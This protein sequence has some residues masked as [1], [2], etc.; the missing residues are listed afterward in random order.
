MQT[1][2]LSVPPL[3]WRSRCWVVGAMI[4][5]WPMLVGLV[6]GNIFVRTPA[7]NSQ[8][9]GWYYVDQLGFYL[10]FLLVSLLVFFL[11]LHQQNRGSSLKTMVLVNVALSFAWMAFYSFYAI[12]WFL[13]HR[14]MPFSR[15]W[16]VFLSLHGINSSFDYSIYWFIATAVYAG[17]LYREAQLRTQQAAD[18]ALRASQLEGRL[19]RSQ[20]DT[21]KAQLQPHFLFNTLNS[22][23][24]CFRTGDNQL[25]LS[26]LVKFS[27]LL[28]Q[29]LSQ[30]EQRAHP[31][32]D[33]LAFL[34]LYLDIE[35]VRFEDR[36]HI[37]R[38]I[39]PAAA[40]EAVP[41]MVL[42]PLVENAIR[43]GVSQSLGPALLKIVAE[44]DAKVLTVTVF[45]DGPLL[46]DN[47][48]SAGE[49]IGLRNTLDRLEVVYGGAAELS[50]HNW[51]TRGVAATLRLPRGVAT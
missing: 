41:V 23:S 46:T 2:A 11:A 1:Q 6:A 21:L 42:Q 49:G 10:P 40:D 9:Y 50:L 27:D 13:W 48:N 26:L 36:L 51:Q 29:S 18:F 14:G 22:I 3:S 44:V 34:D 31:L 37:E 43:H 24:S 4:A 20:L 5:F 39:A 8:G 15:F 45:N 19:V 12:A 30:G 38:A 16:D 25:G 32:R 47:P 35:A 28:R 17:V 33:E 7:A